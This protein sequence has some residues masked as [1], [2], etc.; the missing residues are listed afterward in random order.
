MRSVC[1]VQ[2]TLGLHIIVCKLIVIYIICI[3]SVS[4]N[5]C[6]RLHFFY[7]YLV[8]TVRPSVMMIGM[9]CFI[10]AALAVNFSDNNE[11][12]RRRLAYFYYYFYYYS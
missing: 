10:V 8:H 9:S 12:Q 11:R 7:T 6:V 3:R 4:L 1:V 5:E 2:S